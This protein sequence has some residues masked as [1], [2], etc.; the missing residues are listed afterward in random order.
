MTDGAFNRWYIDHSV[1][2]LSYVFAIDRLMETLRKRGM[3]R[4]GHFGQCVHR[5]DGEWWDEYLYAILKT[6]H[7]S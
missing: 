2:W 4:E 1:C 5:E 7:V 6:E 3:R